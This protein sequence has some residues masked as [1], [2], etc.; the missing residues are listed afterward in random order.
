[1]LVGKYAHNMLTFKV[2]IR[3]NEL[4]KDGTYNVKIRM[5]LNREVKRLST[6]IFVRP[7]DLT[8]SFKLKNPV[9][10][11]EADALVRQYQEIC[12]TLPLEAS[13]YSIAEVLEYIRVEQEKKKSIDF[14]QF[15]HEWLERTEIKGKKNYKTALN[16][17][18]AYLG[19]EALPIQQVTKDLLRGFM[20]YLLKRRTE[21]IIELERK[22]KRIPSNRTI[23]LYLGSIRHLFNEAKKR[24][25]D[26]DRNIILIPNS[27]FEN[28]D[29]P[30]QEAT[31]KRALPVEAIRQ[32]WKLPYILNSTNGKV[33]TC[34]YNLAKD[35]FILSFCLIGMNS[36]DLYNCAELKDNIITYYRTKTK[37][38]RQDK[39]KMQIHVPAMIMPLMQRYKDFT[40][41]RVFNFY[42]LYSSA[43]NF[44]KAINA[45]L[46]EIGRQL[47]IED[48]EYY[49]ARHSWATLAVNKVGIDKYTVHAALNHIDEAMKVTDIYIE[50][51]FSLENEAN[52]KVLDFVFGS[53][54][55]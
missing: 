6:N 19:K 28:F 1:M 7:C 37:D 54:G 31:R 12:A 9:F 41:K 45:G 24:Y 43:N 39:A 25:N 26:Y 36:A 49:A 22:G 16:S 47:R 50:R 48:L 46:K 27:P 5:T 14:I 17:F 33:R 10:I 23:S 8:K 32:I 11:K 13:A 30:K 42:H 15:C 38:R 18:I 2:E 53:S 3:K 21:R 29:V 35:C 44:N 34:P 52:R 4:K 51:D 40:G 20:E 55:V